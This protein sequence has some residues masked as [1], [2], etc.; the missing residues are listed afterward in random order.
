MIHL[1]CSWLMWLAKGCRFQLN[2]LGFG[3]S[4]IGIH[5]QSVF[6]A[7]RLLLMHLLL[8]CALAGLTPGTLS[9]FTAPVAAHFAGFLQWDETTSKA[10]FLLMVSPR[11][12]LC[13]WTLP[14]YQ[15]D[16]QVI[17]QYACLPTSPR[18][19]SVLG[20]TFVFKHRCPVSC[21][22]PANSIWK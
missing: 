14:L 7:P 12:I 3:T 1:A 21:L 17:C 18:F 4:I 6:L 20:N 5:P 11:V 2:F 22:T 16:W 10:V 15:P 13:W 9:P 19:I 8:P